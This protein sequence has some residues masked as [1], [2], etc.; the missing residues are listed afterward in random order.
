MKAKRTVVEELCCR[1]RAVAFRVAT[2][3]TRLCIAGSTYTGFCCHVEAM[4]EPCG[5][6]GPPRVRES[7][8]FVCVFAGTI[9]PPGH[10]LSSS[11]ISRIEPI[12][13]GLQRH[14]GISLFLLLV[15]VPGVLTALSSAPTWRPCTGC[16]T[17]QTC[18]DTTTWS[19]AGQLGHWKT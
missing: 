7:E 10:R 8:G 16:L 15:P 1:S 14:I 17:S 4:V 19:C 5:A 18:P 9:V 2:L 13:R 11:A 12:L 3:P 6:P